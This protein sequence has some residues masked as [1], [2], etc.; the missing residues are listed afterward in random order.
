MQEELTDQIQKND[1]RLILADV[2]LMAQDDENFCLQ[3]AKE[4]REKELGLRLLQKSK[5]AVG[6]YGK[7]NEELDEE[8]QNYEK[9]LGQL[10]DAKKF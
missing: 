5:D 2:L 4:Q 8:I 7:K 10:E 6:V 9:V 1:Q 3:K